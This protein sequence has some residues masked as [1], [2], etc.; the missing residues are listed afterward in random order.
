MLSEKE[1]KI[2]TLE[3]KLRGRIAKKKEQ[4]ET[5]YRLNQEIFQEYHKTLTEKDT[6]LKHRDQLLRQKE[7]ECAKRAIDLELQQSQ[8]DS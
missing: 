5:Q 6:E 8:L 3:L 7:E 2:E 4:L 1:S